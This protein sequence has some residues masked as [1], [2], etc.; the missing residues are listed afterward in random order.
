MKKLTVRMVE[1]VLLGAVLILATTGCSKSAEQQI[2]A[3]QE[4]GGK[5]KIGFSIATLTN[6]IWVDMYQNMEKRAAELGVQLYINDAN[7]TA[8]TQ[9]AGIEN[10]LTMGCQVIIVHAF[11]YEAAI[12]IV[13]EAMSRGV[14]VISYDVELP[15]A[16]AFSG[17]N[18]TTLGEYMGTLAGQWINEN[19]DG[20]G[21]VGILGV[22]R[23][24]AILERENGI[25]AG[26]MK[27]A[28]ESVI[29]PTIACNNTA[30]AVGAGENL[31]QMRPDINC[32]VSIADVFSLGV[33]EAFM[34]AD[35]SK[36]NIGIFGCDAVPDALAA[37]AQGD[38]YR[39]TIF[40]D[41]V[42]AGARMIDAAVKM[43]RGEPFD[44]FI[45]LEPQTVTFEN[46][47]EFMNQ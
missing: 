27:T 23:I 4:A 34:A 32:V 13:E 39:G 12:P 41:A 6:P 38:I 1:A 22:P 16:D 8:A 21:V 3:P 18:N 11:E 7:N 17:V 15:N 25:K 45:T 47:Q 31:L 40:L 30:E 29:L 9:I 19:A 44:P 36:T 28:P 33:F 20:K 43:T 24:T 10:F 46:V 26:I 35:K 42:G 14:K 2:A 5:I 37:I